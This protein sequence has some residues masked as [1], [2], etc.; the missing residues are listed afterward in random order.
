MKK[1]LFAVLCMVAITATASAQFKKVGQNETVGRYMNKTITISKHIANGDVTYYMI[2]QDASVNFRH[3]L[4][5][6]KLGNKENAITFF[7]NMLNGWKEMK[8][9]DEFP[10]LGLPDGQTGYCMGEFGGKCFCVVCDALGNFGRIYKM[11]L[12]NI[13][14]DLKNDQ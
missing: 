12:E 8:A 14:Y 6:V 9:G 3:Y 4:E 7:T 2:L 11:S 1:L 13:I 10:D 5:P